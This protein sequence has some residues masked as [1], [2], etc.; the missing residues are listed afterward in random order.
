MFDAGEDFRYFYCMDMEFITLQLSRTEALELQA[1]LVSRAMLEDD[2]RHEKG[3]EPVSVRSTLERLGTL[4]QMTTGQ[5][6]QLAHAMDDELWEFAWYRFTDEWAWYRASQ[7]V[8]KE[9][10]ASSLS[11]REL[12]QRIEQRYERNFESYV[13]ELEMPDDGRSSGSEKKRKTA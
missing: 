13:K 9:S 2:L 4:L 12:Q 3:L 6:E 8:E 5:E 1:A 11:K 10:G 7:E